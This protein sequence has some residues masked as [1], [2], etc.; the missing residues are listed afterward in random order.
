MPDSELHEPEQLTPATLTALPRGD[1]RGN[2]VDSK[3]FADAMVFRQAPPDFLG[4]LSAQPVTD[5]DME[6]A[7]GPVQMTGRQARLGPAL[8]QPFPLVT[9][10][11]ERIRQG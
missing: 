3:P 2:G 9:S 10:D 4:H 11:L 1:Q 5:R 7:L 6:A 8:E